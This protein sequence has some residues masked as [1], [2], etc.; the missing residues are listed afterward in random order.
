MKTWKLCGSALISVLSL[1]VTS[2]GQPAPAAPAAGTAVPAAAPAAPSGGT[3]LWSFLGLSKQ[4]LG[5]LK[6]RFCQSSIGQLAGNSLKPASAMSGGLLPNCCPKALTD[7]ALAKAAAEEAKEPGSTKGSATAAA[8]KIMK[9]E[10]EAKQRR[11]AVRYLGTVDC[12]YWGKVAEPALIAALRGDKNECVRFE[13]ALALGNGCCCTADTIEALT[14]SAFGVGRIRVTE[15]GV[16]IPETVAGGIADG[17]RFV[18]IYPVETSERVRAAA[19][20]AL[21][22]CLACYNEPGPPPPEQP[23]GPQP[24]EIPK[25]KST[26]GRLPATVTSMQTTGYPAGDQEMTLAQVVEQAR[27]ISSHY[28]PVGGSGVSLPTGSHSISQI[29]AQAV[30]PSRG[31]ETIPSTPELTP[32][33]GHIQQTSAPVLDKNASREPLPLSS[34]SRY[35]GLIPWLSR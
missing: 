23:V 1:S 18:D 4:N 29:F 34:Q 26:A 21:Q 25:T 12:H 33:N 22:N 19:Y 32:A 8:A 7:D 31:A 13:A 14:L 15:K 28:S 24:P 9:D 16:K 11:A 17:K 10:A 20:A 2:W 6:V 27:R 5:N 3:T 30:K 35:G